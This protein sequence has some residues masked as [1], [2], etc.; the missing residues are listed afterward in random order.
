MKDIHYRP[1]ILGVC[2]LVLLSIHLGACGRSPESATFQTDARDDNDNL[3]SVSNS[4]P[5]LYDGFE[6]K[7]LGDLWMPGNYGSGRYVPGAIILSTNYSRSGTHSAE[8]TVRE[9][10]I[11]AAGDD[12]TRVE[13]AELDSGHFPLRGRDAWYGFSLLHVR[14]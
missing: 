11:D 9:G 6:G 3:A 10:D 8:I 4:V 12:D 7:T 1:G 14:V 2:V 13:R 5:V